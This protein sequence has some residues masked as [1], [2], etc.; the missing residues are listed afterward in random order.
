M[1]GKKKPGF[2]DICGTANE[3]VEVYDKNHPYD[4]KTGS[5]LIFCRARGRLSEFGL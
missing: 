3:F 5:L 2:C 1:F 4:P